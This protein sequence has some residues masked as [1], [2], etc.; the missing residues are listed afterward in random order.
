MGRPG[1]GA[2]LARSPSPAPSTSA[3]FARRR[4]RA[5]NVDLRGVDRFVLEF[6]ASL[7]PV[8]GGRPF[9]LSRTGYH[10]EVSTA[11]RLERRGVPVLPRT[12]AADLNHGC[13]GRDAWSLADQAALASSGLWSSTSASGRAWGRS[14]CPSGF[15]ARGIAHPRAGRLSSWPSA[16]TGRSRCAGALAVFRRWPECSR[17]SPRS[18]RLWVGMLFSTNGYRVRN[19]PVSGDHGIDLEVSQPP[20]VTGLVQCKRYRGTVGGRRAGDQQGRSFAG[21][22]IAPGSPRRRRSPAGAPR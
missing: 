8:D 19:T 6:Q 10:A 17:W 4:G 11:A 3:S 2:G 7:L 1:P 5:T 13:A 16:G 18:S 15:R 20:V 12:Q 14:G 22:R 21:A 9:G